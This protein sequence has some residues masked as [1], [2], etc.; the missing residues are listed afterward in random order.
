[1]ALKKES[2]KASKQFIT[3]FLNANYHNSETP[4]LREENFDK[5]MKDFKDFIIKAIEQKDETITKTQENK[6]VKTDHFF[7]QINFTNKILNGCIKA[8]EKSHK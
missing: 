5:L 1:M 4:K 7:V 6:D 2:I 8:T 3:L